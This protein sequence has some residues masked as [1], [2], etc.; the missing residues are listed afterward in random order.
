VRGEVFAPVL[1]LGAVI[2]DYQGQFARGSVQMY[3]DNPGGQ[4]RL[5]FLQTVNFALTMFEDSK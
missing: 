3:G 1:L 5:Q 2:R 4:I